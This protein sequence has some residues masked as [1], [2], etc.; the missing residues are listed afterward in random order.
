MKKYTAFLVFF[1]VLFLLSG[2]DY[3]SDA[4]IYV[5]LPEPD[6]IGI[7]E[8][9]AGV[10]A[11][12]NAARIFRLCYTLDAVKDGQIFITL[13]ETV[14]DENG[15]EYPIDSFGGAIGTNAPSQNF[16]L[17]LYVQQSASPEIPVTLTIDAG[18]LPLNTGYWDDVEIHFSADGTV[19]QVP[20]DAV[21]FLSDEPLVYDLL[22]KEEKENGSVWDA[23]GSEL[24]YDLPDTEYRGGDTVVLRLKPPKEGHERTVAVRAKVLEPTVTKEAYIQYEFIMPYHDVTVLVADMPG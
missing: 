3:Y 17:V 4:Y 12:K 8:Y 21:I 2:C 9:Q 16:E 13:P 7:N 15:T 10:S 19:T 14:V 23:R 24:W 6:A 11:K 20:L 5:T 22:L 18:A 1:L